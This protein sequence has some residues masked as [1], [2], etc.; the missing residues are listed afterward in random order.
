[1][2]RLLC[3]GAVIAVCASCGG[4]RESTTIYGAG[5]SFPNPIY[6]RWAYSFYQLNG[7][8]I[9]YESNGSSAGINQVKAGTV[10]FGGSDAPLTQKEL[11]ESGLVQFPMIIGGIVP[12]VHLEGV[13]PGELKL[14]PDV[15]ARIFLGEIKKWNDPAIK[16]MN[17]DVELPDMQITPVRRADGSGTTWIFTNYL[18]AVH[19]DWKEK[20]GVGKEV[21]WPTGLGGKGNEGV[22]TNVQ[23]VNGSIGYVEYAY[24]VQNK[25]T[26]AQL[27]NKAG[28][29]VEPTLAS[30]E[31]AAANADWAHAPGFYLVLVDQ[32]GDESWPIT[33]ASFILIH[34]DQSDPNVARSMLKFFDW[35]YRHGADMAKELH[36]VPLPSSVYELV[37]QTWDK[38]V[39]SQGKPVER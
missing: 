24:A 13:K 29:F 15:F 7:T 34:K 17:A 26:H 21:K 37:A 36:Y 18:A 12:V 10:S 3:F 8:R 11:D 14:S 20:V 22:A 2:N 25:M 31:A 6:S 9:N 1:M 19:A 30:F 16:D 39:R 5:A 4:C 27:R 33:G 38:E 23:Q 28:K 32:P 35:C